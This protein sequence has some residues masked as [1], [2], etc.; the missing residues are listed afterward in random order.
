RGA[1]TWGDGAI[2]VTGEVSATNSLVG[3]QAGDSVGSS[4]VMALSNGNYVVASSNWANGGASKAGAV[5]WG[6]GASGE[7]TGLV[8]DANSLVG[9]RA[10]DSV[11]SS[12]VTVLTN[13]N[14]VVAS[15]SWDSDTATDVGAVTWGNGASGVTGAVSD[16]NS[17]VGSTANDKV[18]ANGVTALTNGNYVVRSSNWNN[19]GASKAGAVTWGNGEGG[20]VGEVSATNSLVGKTANDFVGSNGVTALTNGNYVVTSPNWDSDTATNVGAV[21]WGNGEGGT[22]GEVS[23]D[24]SLVGATAG[25]QVGNGYMM[26]LANGNYVVGSVSWANIG[27]SKAG[28]VTWGNGEGGTVGEVSATNSLVGTTADDEVGYNGVI[29]LTNGNYVVLSDRW[30][31]IG[32]ANAGAVTWGNGEGGT[33]GE[34]SKDNSLVGTTADDR[35][36]AMDEDPNNPTYLYKATVIALSNGN[37]VVASPDWNADTA[38][39]VGAVTWGDG[40]NGTIGEVSATNSLVGVTADDR[41]G[42]GDVTAL[43]N[44]NYV[45][46][47]PSWDNDG[48][49][50]AGAVTWGSGT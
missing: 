38:N 15:Q 32:A 12:G 45:V 41:V 26:A 13:G 20:T 7:T 2:G 17:L 4:G 9:S 10:S 30:N 21:T 3:S 8:S 31:N 50:N 36:G 35:V 29:E 18:G 40:V 16:A 1:V 11:G 25:D 43:T 33:V 14:Y 6:N 19:I 47:S 39:T 37:Y 22:V 23:K 5:T 34:V 24:N 28:A 49:L 44:G 42:S 27:A 48:V 46:A